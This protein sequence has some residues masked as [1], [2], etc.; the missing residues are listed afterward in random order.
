MRDLVFVHL[1][2]SEMT[3][4]TKHTKVVDVYDI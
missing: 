4:D 1:S 2:K 3:R